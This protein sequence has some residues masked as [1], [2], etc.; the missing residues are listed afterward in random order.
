M[1]NMTISR[2]MVVLAMLVLVPMAVSAAVSFSATRELGQ[3]FGTYRALTN[4]TYA[5]TGLVSSL[6]DARAAVIGTRTNKSPEAVAAARTALDTLQKEAETTAARYAA[7][8]R[9]AAR[10]ESMRAQLVDFAATFER[11]VVLTAEL[12]ALGLA[13]VE[14]GS[15][16]RIDMMKLFRAAGRE[17]GSD[18]LSVAGTAQ[19]NILLGR[20]YIERFL[21]NL[22][23]EDYDT[24]TTWLNAARA[25][26]NELIPL[27]E[28]ARSRSLALGTLGFV[29]GLQQNLDLVR[30]L[31][32]EIA[33][34]QTETLDQIGPAMQ[35]DLAAAF[36]AVDA[37]QGE[38]GALGGQAAATTARKVLVVAVVALL[39]GLFSAAAMGRSVSQALRRS[40]GQMDALAEGRLDVEI[41]GDAAKSELGQI[42][43]SLKVFRQSA[44]R[45]AELAEEKRAA[46]AAAEARKV[47]M[48][49][50]LE[51]SFGSAVEAGVAG[52]FSARVP[53]TFADPVL[54]RLAAGLNRLLGSVEDSVDA[55]R[56]TL[57]AVADGALD[58]TMRGQFRGV[59]AELQSSVN[60]TIDS[61]ADI[62]S[63]IAEASAALEREARSIDS[64][65]TD[66][67]DR[68]SKQAAALEQTSAAMEEMAITTKANAKNANEASQFA[69]TAT[70]QAGEGANVADQT[71]AKMSEI[72]AGAAEISG[73]V[74]VIDSIAFQTNL[75]AL[76]AAVEAARAGES[77]KGFAVV[78]SEVRTLAQRS[79]DAARDIRTLIESS[80]TQVGSGVGLV[81]DMGTSLGDILSGVRKLSQTMTSI[82]EAS[83]E[84]AQGLGGVTTSINHIDR[85]TQENAAMA[86]ASAATARS[87]VNRAQTL[88]A[89]VATFQISASDA[90]A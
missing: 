85:I 5:V 31:Q 13:M 78:A 24:T 82:K 81:E 44:Q 28:R 12:E 32:G 76:N 58:N 33:A 9:L 50:D 53:E 57:A 34:L 15:A 64:G 71:I 22:R 1:E 79:A 61:L 45:V 89:L 56:Q 77:G 52:D 14:D 55:T 11:T 54:N 23:P 46:D 17:G 75:L 18:A 43:R 19:Q 73:I 65:A 41:T 84:Q 90:A 3:H 42:A 86:D 63:R 27:L 39:I 7:D 60:G 51:T 20:I 25:G 72:E 26:I 38:I 67:S 10:L 2:R 74:T 66:L 47:A 21:A 16:A 8:P 35:A 37:A 6:S 40:I 29:T 36:S 62:V 48:L 70:K 80:Q 83:Q 88:R 59:F 68:A 30:D 49:S 69:E 87:L 4:Q